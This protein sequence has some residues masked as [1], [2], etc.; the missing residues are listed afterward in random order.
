MH[1]LSI[2]L[3]ILDRVEEEAARRGYSIVKA[4]HVRLGGLSG[5]IKTALASAF[6]LAREGTALAE[7]ELVVEES[8]V[9]LHCAACQADQ[10]VPSI[11]EICCPICGGCD[12]EVIGGR[13]LEVTALEIA[14]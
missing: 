13:E 7:C 6:D 11:Q 3:S 8:P 10:P 4:V 12:V 1:E 14:T 9:I 2:A 5:V